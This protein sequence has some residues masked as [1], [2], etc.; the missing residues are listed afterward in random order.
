MKKQA[1][2]SAAGTDK[3]V[4]PV[5]QGPAE[6]KRSSRERMLSAA[7]GLFL[8]DGY[9]AVSVE[10]IARAAQVSRMTFYRHFSGKVD[11]SIEL[12][13]QEVAKAKPRYLRIARE[14]FRDRDVIREWIAAQFEADRGNRGLLRVFSQ[15]TAEDAEF[16]QKAQSLIS[17][18]ISELGAS[19]PAFNV[20]PNRRGERRRWLEAWLLIFEILDQSNHAALESGVANDPL[21][22]DILSDRFLAFVKSG[23]SGI[24]DS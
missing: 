11:L 8:Q 9:I 13:R 17:E 10:D 19:I 22:V 5:S 7:A 24:N 3:V 18:L 16:T 1:L 4:S 21:V 20:R 14:D 15:M 23:E 6:R 2:K 12:F